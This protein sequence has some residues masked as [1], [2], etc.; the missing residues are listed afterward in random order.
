MCYRWPILGGADDK[1]ETGDTY[2]IV[3]SGGFE[4]IAGISLS[5]FCETDGRERMHVLRFS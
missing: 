1:R 5:K 4:P 3:V 2:A